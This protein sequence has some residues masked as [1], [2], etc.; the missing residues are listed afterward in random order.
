M[1]LRRILFGLI[2]G[3]VFCLNLAAQTREV[4][5]GWKE[6][7]FCGVSFLLPK[8]MKK[9]TDDARPYDS[10]GETFKGGNLWLGFSQSMY[11]ELRDPERGARREETIID[12]R[13]A[14]IT[15]RDDGAS[16]FIVVFERP[17]SRITLGL[18]VIGR[19]PAAAELALRIIRSLRF[20]S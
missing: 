12:G 7:S 4:P 18:N 16:V 14:I 2:L 10:C 8:N 19:P 6:V 11:G 17:D 20:G 15:T 5:K 1:P 9:Q 3:S 13:R